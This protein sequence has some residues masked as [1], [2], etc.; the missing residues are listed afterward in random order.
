M[1]FSLSKPGLK[2]WVYLVD[3]WGSSLAALSF[4][5]FFN[6]LA[7]G[8]TLADFES[9][10]STP[11]LSPAG[12][13]VVTNPDMNGNSSNNVAHYQKP[14]GNWHAVYL[15]FPAKK[16]ISK[17]DRLTFKIRSATQGRVYV[18][19]I[20]NGSAIVENWAPDYS[21]QPI[22]ATWTEVSF[23]I[24]SITDQ[25]FDRIE[26]NAS[27]DNEAVSEVYLD[28]FKLINSQAPDG[29]PI[30]QVLPSSYQVTE[31]TSIH[32]DGSGS[33]DTDGSIE[34][35]QWDFNDGSTGS[36]PEVDHTFLTE[37]IF[38]VTLTVQDN[39]AKSSSK[40][41]G[42]NVLPASN[43]IGSLLFRTSSP[44]V[45]EK[46]E[47]VFLLKNSYSNVYDPDVVKVDAIITQPDLVKI[48]VP[49]FYYQSAT[50][51]PDQWTQSEGAG[52]W[53][54]R[55]SPS[56]TG[57]HQIELSLSD[58]EGITVSHGYE[59]LVE[60]SAA[61]GFIGIDPNNKQYF[62]HTTGEPY[63]PLGINVAWDNTSNYTKI[64][65][66]LGAGGANLVR[67]WQ[68]PFDRQG[69]EWK[70]GSGFYKGLGVYS[71]EA[72]AEQ[73]SIFALC[74]ANNIF[75]QVTL[76]QH[77]MFSENV[78]SNWPDNPYNSIN[79]GPLTKA[80]QYFY[81]TEA[82]TRTKKL[83]R[84]IVARWGYSR[85][86][87]AWEL[88]NEVNFT[89]V[90]PN[91]TSQWYPG[92]KAWHDEM[93]QYIKAQD[94]FHHPVTTSSDESHLADFDKLT[95]L[96][97]VQYHLY[98]QALLS[99][100]NSKDKSISNLMTRVGLIN[101]EYGLDVSTADVPFD[102]QRV[103]VWTGIMNQVPHLMWLWQNYVNAD[104][105]NLFRY[106]ADF[107]MDED[108]V[109]EGALSDWSFTAT[110][111][112][113]DAGTAGFRS[114][115]NFYGIVYDRNYGGN[116]SSATAD[117]S[118]LPAGNYN[119]TFVDL[120][121]G[122]KTETVKDIYSPRSFALPAFSKGIAFKGK[123]NYGII[124]EADEKQEAGYVV[125][126]NP[127]SDYVYVAIPEGET[128]RSVELINGI[129]L[130]QRFSLKELGLSYGLYIVRITTSTNIF[131]RK[132]IYSSNGR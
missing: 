124:L 69:L 120:L 24:S 19:I 76:F 5:L 101:G 39:D 49:C 78:N 129:P 108:F 132:L 70:N 59:F 113:E 73:D 1:L 27:V 21:S 104:W 102:A 42:I 40:T 82:K 35:F 107:I 103:A 88:F 46:T 87:F 119:L 26:V 2:V 32:F 10:E 74:E 56:Q 55:F 20:N 15:D 44:K 57:Q 33:S 81:N 52:H 4:L 90:Y 31:G 65:E 45:Y 38:Y 75:L 61:R 14:S 18:K 67:Y 96:D 41:L 58:A 100:Q 114:E 63:Y 95:G 60:E 109:S 30:V 115:K 23:N 11:L 72:A 79:G 47:A 12:A 17:N 48:T 91:Q 8:Q 85:H 28:D 110:F 54:I 37:G 25:E 89:G 112:K 128:L 51:A 22:S 36:G 131:Y 84:Y 130:S 99:T 6:G 111:N 62:R 9:V 16:N 106:P 98:N 3:E 118:S 105:G 122:V 97:N 50:Y 34:S 29:Q 93:G 53:M 94:V 126:P 13:T 121:T 68:V 83:L 64:F 80:E 71:Q 86:L 127:S 117:F 92:V 43:N 7:S 125:Y 77:G 123:L 116:I 66:N